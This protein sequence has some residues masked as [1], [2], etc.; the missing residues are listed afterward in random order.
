MTAPSR[1]D[2]IVLRTLLERN[3]AE[4]P[5]EVFVHFENGETWTRAEAL[6]AAYIAGNRLHD[7]GVRQGDRVAV[8]LPNGPDFLRAWWGC[9]AIGAVVAPMNTGYRGHLL[10]GLVDLVKPR[11]IVTDDEL[12]AR[13]TGL[14]QTAAQVHA[15]TLRTGP[16]LPPVLD[17]PL[18][19]GDPELLV[20]TSGTTG[21][22]KLVATSYLH[23]YLGGAHVVGTGRGKEERFLI[24][25]PMFHSAMLYMITASLQMGPS[26]A[27]RT[28]PS[29][30]RY[31]EVARDTGATMAIMLS[32]MTT[33]LAAQ[34]R[35]PAESEHNLRTVCVA[36]VPPDAAGFTERFN[37]ETMYTTY[38]STEIPGATLSSPGDDLRPGFCGQPRQGFECRIVDGHDIEVAVGEPG[39]LIVRATEPWS[40]MT[41]Y[42]DNPEATAVAWR[43]GWFHTGDMMYRDAAGGLFFVDRLK[44]ALRRRGENVSSLEVEAIIAKHDSV[45]E[46]AC[47]PSRLPGVAEDEVKIFVVVSE[48]SHLD[49]ES[50]FLYCADHLPHF[51]VPRFIELVDELPRTPSAKIKKVALKELGN[52]EATWDAERAGL[53]ITRRGV[54][55]AET[56]GQAL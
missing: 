7:L 47:V 36:P 55:R 27:I 52:T 22:S 25:L 51:M 13:L 34:E 31:W 42:V 3:A 8:F 29:M 20:L 15:A 2:D 30:S 37:I 41:E 44:D 56:S 50:L 23:N 33:F 54:V 38:G 5:D 4:A 26:V 24:D 17:R 19:H 35:R 14:P 1:P 28:A 40:M 6:E 21:P 32:T 48:G 18:F 10:G 53:R 49:P 11:L 45:A 12:G 9:G 16:S 46:V 39:E 43:N